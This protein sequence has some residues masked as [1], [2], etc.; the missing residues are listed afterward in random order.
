MTM[1]SKER[2][3]ILVTQLRAHSK[4]YDIAMR[5]ITKARGDI[6]EEEKAGRAAHAAGVSALQDVMQYLNCYTVIF[7]ELL[8]RP[9]G[10]I[11]SAVYDAGQGATPRL[12]EHGSSRAGKATLTSREQVQGGLAAA[13]KTLKL[14]GRGTQ[15]AADWIFQEA[16]RHGVVTQDGAEVTAHQLKSWF[17]EMNSRRGPQGAIEAFDLIKRAHAKRLKQIPLADKRKASEALALSVVKS[18]ATNS[19]QSAPGQN[20]QTDSRKRRLAK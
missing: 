18:F 6:V 8:T 12:L 20:R 10:A 11:E 4:A 3:E 17:K 13:I 15:I 19:P 7:D 5:G 1:P 14:G 2:F 9:L 16:K